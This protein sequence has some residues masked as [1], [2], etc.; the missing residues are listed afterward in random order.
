MATKGFS[1][2]GCV[3]A[4]IGSNNKHLMVG[5]STDSNN[6]EGNYHAIM[7]RAI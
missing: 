6:N 1:G 5:L 7:K 4:K 3:I 2:D